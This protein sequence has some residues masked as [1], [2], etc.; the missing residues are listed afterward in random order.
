MMALVAAAAC[1]AMTPQVGKDRLRELV[2]L[3]TISFQADW[4][5]DA[6]RGFTLG[7]GQEDD[8][9]AIDK[10]REGLKSDDRDAETEMQLAQLYSRVNDVTNSEDAWK[11]ATEYYR[12]RVEAQP[13]N[14]LLLCGLGASLEGVGRVDEA[15]SVL[16]RAVDES[17]KDWQCSVALG[18]FLDH[19]ARGMILDP[20]PPPADDAAPSTPGRP[21]VETTGLAEKRIAEATDYFEQAVKDAPGE[22]EPYFRR[23]MHHCLETLVANQIQANGN[24]ASDTMAN[25]L[26]GCFT[27]GNLADIQR[28]SRLSPEDYHLMGAAA[29]FEIYAVTAREGG[30]DWTHLSLESLPEKQRAFIGETITGLEDLS[31]GPKRDAAAGASEVLGILEGPILHE[32]ERSVASMRR[33]VALD[34]SREQSWDVLAATL[35]QSGRYD[36]LLETCEDQLKYNETARTH[37]ML[38]KARE[39]LRQWDACEDEVRLALGDDPADASANLAMGALLLKRSHDDPDALSQADDWL[40]RSEAALREIPPAQRDRQQVIDLTLT[41]GIYFALTD[42]VDTARKWVQTVIDR[43]KDNALAREILAAMNY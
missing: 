24:A 12:K 36:E 2:K 32:R 43:D 31:E 33:A 30:M 13:E 8:R 19:Q 7:S 37:L 22:A 29:L 28:A 27:D 35:A 18:R 34:P 1:R 17:P 10:L 6:E 11:L 4:S 21:S 26:A 5:F 15:E 25:P 41:R 20:P 23:A 39:R 38:A 9:V 42:E 16:R 3:P 14:S 40:L